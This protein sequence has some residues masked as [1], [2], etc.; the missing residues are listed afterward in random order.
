[1]TEPPV[2]R[3]PSTRIIIAGASAAPRSEMEER[4]R[5]TTEASSFAEIAIEKSPSSRTI[6]HK[7]RRAR[8]QHFD[9]VEFCCLRHRD[10][11]LLE[12]AAMVAKIS[13]TMRPVR[14][15]PMSVRKK[16]T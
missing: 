7:G 9:D 10:Q 3:Q 12:V 11:Q 4:T 5:L 1:M 15:G 2:R 14:I 6:G 13:A 16:T 8:R